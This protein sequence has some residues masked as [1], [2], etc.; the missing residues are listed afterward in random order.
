MTSPEKF[1]TAPL[2]PIYFNFE[3]AARAGKTRFFGFF[4]KLFA[5]GAHKIWLKQRLLSALGGSANNLIDLKKGHFN[6]NFWKIRLPALEK[7]L[8]PPL[9]TCVWIKSY[10]YKKKHDTNYH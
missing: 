7:I 6:E 10:N 8:D 5:C 3:G 1:L 9:M 2:E 4:F